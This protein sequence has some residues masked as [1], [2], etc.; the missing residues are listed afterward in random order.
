[1]AVSEKKAT[2][3]PEMRAEPR[4]K[5]RI[6]SNPNKISKEGNVDK[7]IQVKSNMKLI[8]SGSVSKETEIG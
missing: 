2:S 8:L 5:T 7:K 3:D 4:I 6:M 1:L